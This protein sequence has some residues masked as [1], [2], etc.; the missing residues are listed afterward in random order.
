VSPPKQGRHGPSVW[1]NQRSRPFLAVANKAIDVWNLDAGIQ[2]Q[3]LSI[4]STLDECGSMSRPVKAYSVPLGG[5]RRRRF[6]WKGKNTSQN[7]PFER[8]LGLPINNLAKRPRMIC[9]HELPRAVGPDSAKRDSGRCR[10]GHGR[11]AKAPR[12]ASSKTLRSRYSCVFRL[13]LSRSEERLVCG[14]AILNA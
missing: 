10:V 8:E 11:V 12:L 4:F 14:R 2:A 1:L 6:C 7:E 5:W 9:T 13:L 3:R